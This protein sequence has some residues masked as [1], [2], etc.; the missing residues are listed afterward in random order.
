MMPSTRLRGRR[1]RSLAADG[2]SDRLIVLWP[3]RLARTADR[4]AAGTG[5]PAGAGAAAYGDWSV[6]VRP[7]PRTGRPA[8]SVGRGRRRPRRRWRG[9][10][11]GIGRIRLGGPAP[12]GRGRDRRRRL[13]GRP[14]LVGTVGVAWSRWLGTRSVGT[15]ALRRSGRRPVRYGCRRGSAGCEWDVVAADT[16]PRPAGRLAAQDR[17]CRPRRRPAGRSASMTAHSQTAP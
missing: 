16:S 15:L 7:A 8:G 4:R 11:A 5:Q 3:Y 14:V 10:A 12:A 13:G 17:P 1:R 9:Y 6:R 2:S